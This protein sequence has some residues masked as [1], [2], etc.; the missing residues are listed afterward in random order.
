MQGEIESSMIKRA[1]LN[2]TKSRLQF[3]S[4][5]IDFLHNPSFLD[6]FKRS[7]DDTKHT[8]KNN[9]DLT[10]TRMVRATGFT[11]IPQNFL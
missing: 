1:N 7:S 3:V 5:S 11:K 8:L 6:H 4:G 2:Q 9:A 10:L